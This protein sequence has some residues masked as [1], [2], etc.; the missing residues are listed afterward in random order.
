MLSPILHITSPHYA[1]D[2]Y[3]LCFVCVFSIQSS[4]VYTNCYGAVHLSPPRAVLWPS[5]H[6]WPLLGLFV[7]KELK[8]QNISVPCLSFSLSANNY[9]DSPFY[10]PQLREG[11]ATGKYKSSFPAT[12]LALWWYKKKHSGT[13]HLWFH[14]HCTYGFWLLD[15]TLTDHWKVLESWGNW[16][17]VCKRGRKRTAHS[18]T[19]GNS[20]DKLLLWKENA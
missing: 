12:C 2:I 14:Q 16:C 9:P 4:L 8:Y 7:R 13:L 3:N 11:Q 17:R 6:K 15:L 18:L 19:T 1:H 5:F 20:C 10:E